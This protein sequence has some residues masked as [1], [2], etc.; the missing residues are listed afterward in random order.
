MKTWDC[1]CQGE[2][3]CAVFHNVQLGLSAVPAAE[4]WDITSL[5]RKAYKRWLSD[6]YIHCVVGKGL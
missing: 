3:S 1:R 2:W 4:Q 6:R 5:D